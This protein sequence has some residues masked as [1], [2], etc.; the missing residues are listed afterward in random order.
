M[1][2]TALF[3][4]LLVAVAD[5]FHPLSKLKLV[6]I[7]KMPQGRTSLRMCSTQ[8]PVELR[9]SSS[10]DSCKPCEELSAGQV[11]TWADGAFIKKEGALTAADL[12]DVNLLRIVTE[13][14]SDDDTNALLWKCL[15]YFYDEGSDTWS[16]EKVFPKWS[17]K[18]PTPPDMIGITRRYDPE[19]DKHVRNASMDLM[20]SI[21]RDFKGGVKRLSDVGWKG[22]KLSE[23]TPNKTRRAQAVNWLI[24]FREKL[25][26]KTLEELQSERNREMPKDDAV[27][28]LPSEQHYQR[29]RLDGPTER[30]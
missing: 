17:A 1:R 25:F 16:A 5:A 9:G 29:L 26:G 6:R 30:S 2:G 7:F 12:S 14:A 13:Q 8:I 19:T 28:Q 18:F 4:L 20:R 24:Y 3:V 15:G 23:L 10:A 27:Q 22:Y 21:P 11:K